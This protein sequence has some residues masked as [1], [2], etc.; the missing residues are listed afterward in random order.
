VVWTREIKN[1]A[2]NTNKIFT[3]TMGSATDL[4]NEG[5]RRLVVNSV[6]WGLGLEV[7][8]KADVTI[9]GDFKPTMY[10]F[11]TFQ[12]GVKPEDHALKP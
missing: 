10:G 11:G 8:A 5:L 7:P 9:V 2:G 3:T 12:K 4:A 1:E 6:F